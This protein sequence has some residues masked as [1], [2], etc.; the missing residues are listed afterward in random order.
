MIYNSQYKYAYKNNKLFKVNSNINE[1]IFSQKLG[2]TKINIF[3][4]IIL[5][6]SFIAFILSMVWSIYLSFNPHIKQ[7]K[8]TTKQRLFNTML[9]IIPAMNECYALQ[10]NMD[11]LLSLH[12][13]CKNNFNLK[14]IFIDDDSNDGTTELLQKYSSI[15]NVI[16]IH[17]VKPHAQ[18]GKGPALEDAL[19]RISNIVIPQSTLIGIIDADSHLNSNY[20]IKVWHTFEYSNYDL[21]QTRVDIFNTD[22]NLTNMQNFELSI[23][24]GLLQMIRTNWGSALASGNGQFVT[25]SMAQ[26]IGW[27]TSLL[28]DCEFSLRGLLKGY[29]GTFINI[30]SVQQEG[31]KT[32]KKLIRQRIRWCQGGLQCLTKYSFKIIKSNKIPNM[33]KVDIILFLTMPYLSIIITPASIISFLILILYANTNFVLSLSILLALLCIE[34]TTN[35]LMV[36]KQLKA[37][38]GNIKLSFNQIIKNVFSFSLY[39]WVLAIVPFCSIVRQLGGHNSWDKTSHS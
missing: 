10:K 20:L 16:V 26:E 32:I 24:N 36:L 29:F 33:I 37:S 22:S 9:L 11:T 3:I 27:S 39:R 34:Y 2:M 28:E 19:K 8:Y 1:H 15:I 30:D 7:E 35:T 31:V 14:L 21:V 13:Q 38:E 25:M 17:R 18:E 5:S 12:D 23:Y 4:K 6:I